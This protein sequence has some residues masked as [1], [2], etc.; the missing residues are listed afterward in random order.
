MSEETAVKNPLEAEATGTEV[1]FEY[2]DKEY[3][4]E[5]DVE[6]WDLEVMRAYEQGKSI[7][8]AEALLGAKQ[9]AQFMATK[10]KNKSFAKFT[11]KMFEALGTTEGE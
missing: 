11:E 1:T 5:G 4:I 2:L 8:V 7:A 10:P 9:W 6:E 3:K